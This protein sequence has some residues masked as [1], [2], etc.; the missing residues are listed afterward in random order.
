MMFRTGFAGW[1][2][3]SVVALFG[4]P[5]TLVLV[6]II[7]LFM[8]FF[9]EI[10]SN[11]AATSMMV[12]VLLAIA[13]EGGQDAV[14]LAITAAMASS[15]AF[16]LPVATPPNAL[17]YGTGFFR[18]KDMIKTGFCLEIVGWFL[19]VFIA[20]VFGYKVFGLFKF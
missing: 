12:P 4:K 20:Y 16:M 6:F 5:S 11:T 3:T 18:I 1:L 15:M 19:T 17:V 14:S 8:A 9:T 2:A 7:V 10:T 13:R